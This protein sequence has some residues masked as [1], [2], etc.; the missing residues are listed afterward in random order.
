MLA[1]ES[2]RWY[3][4]YG[5]N[6]NTEQL[7]SR[8]GRR[9]VTSKMVY[10]RDY[11][12]VF[13]KPACD[14]T[15]YA[16]IRPRREA[17]VFGVIYRLTEGE[18]KKLDAYE[19]V[20]RHYRRVRIEVVLENEDRVVAETYIAVLTREGLRPSE[21]YLRCIIQGAVQHGLPRAYVEHLRKRAYGTCD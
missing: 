16:N 2:R 1:A 11:E 6:M 17:T 7:E 5:S 12:L 8:I 9:G 10:L 3:F 15:G 19:G 21:G 20:P 13:D 18:L 14:G 4:A